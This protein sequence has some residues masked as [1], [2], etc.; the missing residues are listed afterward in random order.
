MAK[1][2]LIAELQERGL[3][4]A[5]AESLT[6]GL[7]TSRITET[8]GASAVFLGGIVAYQNSVKQELLGVSGGLLANQG[9]VDAEVAAQMAIG[10][11]SR[12]AK[13]AQLSTD[14]VIGLS[15]TGVAG[16]ESS[17][18]KP[19][20]TVFIGLSSTS[21]DSVYAYDFAGSRDEVREQTVQAALT[22]L[23]E[24]LQLPSGY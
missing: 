1:E 22:V 3:F 11:R 6:A 10:V 24:Q 13:I 5:C 12:F 9:A 2:G 4:L 19:P 23:R 18:T 16:P 20:G 15:T 7:L 8:P 21:G 17:E 14:L